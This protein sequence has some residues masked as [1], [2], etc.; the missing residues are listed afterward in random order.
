MC[1][2]IFFLSKNRK[3]VLSVSLDGGIESEKWNSAAVCENVV[4]ELFYVSRI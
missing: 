4:A 1:E 3:G 2:Y